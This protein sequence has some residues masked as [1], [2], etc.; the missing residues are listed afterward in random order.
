MA[1]VVAPTIDPSLVDRADALRQEAEEKTGPFQFGTDANQRPVVPGFTVDPVIPGNMLAQ[2]EIQDTRNIHPESVEQQSAERTSF[3]SDITGIE[4][5]LGDEDEIEEPEPP[6]IVAE[7][8]EEYEEPEIAKA[9]AAQKKAEQ[10]LDWYKEKWLEQGRKNWREEA[11]RRFPLANVDAIK[12]DS[13]KS[14]LR[15]AKEQHDYVLPI[16]KPHLKQFEEER[17]TAYQETRDQERVRLRAAYGNPTTGP[18]EP[19]I[20]HA[21]AAA[22]ADALDRRHFKTLQDRTRALVRSGKLQI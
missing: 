1:E 10:Q 8:E 6:T 4:D 18:P 20:E 3:D 15:A 11:K 14:F 7:E 16:V 12:A 21:A 2:L 9:K 13:R 5:L 17:A 22:E 19:M